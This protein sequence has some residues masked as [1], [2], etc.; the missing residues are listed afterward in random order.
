[1]RNWKVLLFYVHFS[2]R[3]IF[4]FLNFAI[5]NEFEN[6][7]TGDPLMDETIWKSFQH[8]YNL[9]SS[10]TL[11]NVNM[12]G[13][14]QV[15]AADACNNNRSKHTARGQLPIPRSSTCG[16]RLLAMGR[17]VTWGIEAN[18]VSFD[19]RIRHPVLDAGG[20]IIWPPGQAS[21]RAIGDK[22]NW[23]ESA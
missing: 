3:Y 9:W 23:T 10:L 14:M 19:W 12:I 4:I 20:D 17:G 7:T 2:A 1:M 8:N 15:M 16:S 22:E 21:L 11:S 13:S 18:L 6:L 5:I